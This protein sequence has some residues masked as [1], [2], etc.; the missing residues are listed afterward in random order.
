LRDEDFCGD[1]WLKAPM[2]TGAFFLEIISA[3]AAD[4][5][6]SGRDNFFHPIGNR[7]RPI[8]VTVHNGEFTEPLQ[9]DRRCNS[10]SRAFALRQK[11]F[12]L[13]SIAALLLRS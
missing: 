6:S 7:S 5:L 4:F 3:Y 1:S 10:L 12:G 8:S 11:I 9:R 2:P 13:L